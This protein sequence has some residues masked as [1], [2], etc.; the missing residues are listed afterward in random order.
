MA[1]KATKKA[2]AEAKAIDAYNAKIRNEHARIRAQIL[3]LRPSWSLAALEEVQST[4]STDNATGLRDILD[5]IRTA[6]A[7]D[8]RF[9]GS[10]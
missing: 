10:R 3:E 1:T 9:G 6:D 8:A 4:F 2:A 5:A 7:L